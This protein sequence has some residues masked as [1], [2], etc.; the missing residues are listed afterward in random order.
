MKPFHSKEISKV[1]NGNGNF[2]Q[3]YCED[4][5]FQYDGSNNLESS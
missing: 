4:L 2:E 5:Y 3:E 1:G